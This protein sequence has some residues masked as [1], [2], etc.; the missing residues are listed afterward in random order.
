MS[1]RGTH[2]PRMADGRP[3]EAAIL[4]LADPVAREA[5]YGLVD[6]LARQAAR[7]TVE[8]EDRQR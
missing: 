5:I 7:E 6:L 1:G 2:V 8:A 4:A 3:D